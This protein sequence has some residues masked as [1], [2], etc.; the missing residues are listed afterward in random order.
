MSPTEA[1]EPGTRRAF[2]KQSGLAVG[3]G[4]AWGRVA[5]AAAQGLKPITAS[6]SVSTFVYYAP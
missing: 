3:A 6:H 1:R 2:L 5:R 4:L